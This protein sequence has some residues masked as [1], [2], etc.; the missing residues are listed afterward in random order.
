MSPEGQSEDSSDTGLRPALDS[1]GDP[2]IQAVTGSGTACICGSASPSA[3][4]S[5]ARRALVLLLALLISGFACLL[6][7][8]CR[9]AVVPLCSKPSAR[10]RVQAV[11]PCYRMLASMDGT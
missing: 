6:N 1:D 4:R 9:R 5:A 7:S 10:V 3:A 2:Q 11:G 8:S